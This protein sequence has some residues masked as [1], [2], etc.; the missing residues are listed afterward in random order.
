MANLHALKRRIQV[1]QNVSKTT[2]ALQMISASKLR[3]AQ[4]AALSGRPYVEKL[5][6]VSMNLASSIDKENLHEYMKENTSPGKLIIVISPDKGLAGSLV[7][8]LLKE[9]ITN[10]GKGTAFVAIGKKAESFLVRSGRNVLASFPFGTNLPSFDIVYPLVKIVEEQFLGKKVS[11]V[12]IISSKF[13]SVFTQ[14]AESSDIL[15]VKLPDVKKTDE[16]MIFEPNAQDLL[17]EILSHFIEMSIYQN[18]LETYASEQAARMIAMKNATDNAKEVI[19]ELKL[20]YNK[21]R[22]EKITNEILD[23]AGA[24]IALSV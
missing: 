24:T 15:P 18:I 14:K 4:D 6:E 2:R 17:P 12:K 22:Q 20:E 11:K 5:T 7:S 23:I 19:S 1:A 9:V 8:N 13:Q 21:G 3:K 10:E 16:T